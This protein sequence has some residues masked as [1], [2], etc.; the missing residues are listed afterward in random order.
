MTP[1]AWLLNNGIYLVVLGALV[2]WGLHE[3]GPEGMWHIGL[4]IVGL[5]FL[6]FVHELGHFLTAKW[7]DVHVQTFSIGFG[8]AL[9]GCSF[10]RGETTYKIGVIP[11]GGYVNMVG[12]GPEADEEEDYPRSFKNKTVGQRMLIISAGV[13]MNVLVG[14][15]LFL[16]VFMYHGDYRPAGIV[17]AVE[18]GSPSWD[19]GV[20]S[21][22]VIRS[23]D[24][25]PDPSFNDLRVAVVL[26][27]AGERIPFTF[28][29]PGGSE[30]KLDL[31]PRRDESDLNPVIG[32]SA[33]EQ[34]KL[35]P[36][37]GRKTAILPV[38][39]G[40]AAAAARPLGL[41]PGDVVVASTDPDH[42]GEI[43]DLPADGDQ[44]YRELARR[45]KRL[46]GQKVVLRVRPA[47]E[48]QPD[49]PARG[50]KPDAPARENKTEDREVP[51]EGFSWG[52]RIVGTSRVPD[53]PG[54]AY[55]PFVVQELPRDPRHRHEERYD[56]FEFHRRLQQ[57]AG[58]PM[59]IQVRRDGAPAGS[60]PVDLFVPPAYHYTFG[61]RMKMGEIAALRDGSP[62]V[63]AG[64]QKG[65]LL[66]KVVLQDD[67]G[68]PLGKAL[69]D[70]DPERL[71]DQ[72]REAARRSPGPKKVVLTVRRP[73]SNGQN[74]ELPAVT[75]DDSWDD[76]IEVP[77][78]PGAPL[79]VPQLGLAYRVE[80]RIV[81][82]TPGGP[83][84]KA[85]LED[86]EQTPAPLR[87]HDRIDELRFRTWSTN[88]QDTKWA[89][90]MDLG[91]QRHGETV[92]DG[93]ARI[94][95][96][97]QAMDHKAV[98]LTVSR[99][100]GAV[101]NPIVVEAQEDDT[102]PLVDRGLK[103]ESDYQLQKADSFGQA[104]EMGARKTGGMIKLLY[105]QLRSL[106]TGRVSAKQVGGPIEMG[107]Q[108]FAVARMGYW[109]LLAFLGAISINL[110]VVNFLPIPILDGG[111]MV[112]LI[113]EKLR[114]RPPSEGVRVVATYIGLAAIACL[115]IFVFYQDIRKHI[116]GL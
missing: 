111:H 53:G 12:E 46:V 31:L 40:S 79:S 95:T 89:N 63:R 4:G 10:Q 57:L 97:L 75:W 69:E 99:P 38:V 76:D 88:F 11:L 35:Y 71:P 51:L 92:Y 80:S 91:I 52:D 77:L 112:F 101:K 37:P 73:A 110:A 94:F 3:L 33:S 93:W 70:L 23:L 68:N 65:D 24:G 115:M 13:I 67:K 43:R 36:D 29:M 96:T 61:M 64:L 104:L 83:A 2:G 103:L 78:S 49:A 109:E 18:P 34:L 98:L 26:S 114:G 50:P 58:R 32:V 106:V 86:K 19:Y 100:D 55:D 8:P 20:R 105:M 17:G 81:K 113:Y 62:A 66:I 87:A 116:L 25:T 27:S 48:H 74:L 72:L 82:V 47:G 6:I 108:A 39:A 15:L 59:V 21:A 16:F 85:H 30:L 22:M 84:D 9:P 41:R 102:W 90:R 5:G 54:A 60:A 42:A 44:R 28:Q 14:G 56:P 1:V 7:C 45:L 107:V